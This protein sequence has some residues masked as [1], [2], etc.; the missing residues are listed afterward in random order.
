MA[1]VTL[2]CNSKREAMPSPYAGKP[3][4]S[5][6]KMHVGCMS[7]IFHFLQKHGHGRKRL[8]PDSRSKK[9]KK[10]STTPQKPKSESPQKTSPCEETKPQKSP[11][12][13]QATELRRFS[14]DIPRSPT[15]SQD[16]RNNWRSNSVSSGFRQMG[17]PEKLQ[18]PPG[19]VARLMGLEE[20]P[21]PR[22]LNL[23]EN[24]PEKPQEISPESAEKKR[25]II[26]GALEK[27]DEDLR[28]LRKIIEAVQIAEDF[29][30]S[31]I[32]V[33]DF[34]RPAPRTEDLKNT[35]FEDEEIIKSPLIR[36]LRTCQPSVEEFRR[37]PPSKAGGKAVR[38]SMENR[39]HLPTNPRVRCEFPEKRC[40]DFNSEQPSPV[41]VLD[42]GFFGDD[43][44]PSSAE[45]RL[46][47]DVND[48]DFQ[49]VHTKEFLINKLSFASSPPISCH[50]NNPTAGI[51][52]LTVKKLDSSN[53]K[54]QS[55]ETWENDVWEEGWEKGRV[56]AVLEGKIFG[57][58]IEEI[59]WEL[60]LW[61]APLRPPPNC[62]KRI[63]F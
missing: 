51:L 26:L 27:C 54:L 7:G 3:S 32:K 18:R 8:T 47:P 13:L 23:P 48:K 40:V 55:L 41:S 6:R 24:L 56:G 42:G 44:S 15:L 16:I 43:F 46:K 62:R 21:S 45:E 39:D 5:D 53:L 63:C 33:E 34:K 61:N 28:A 60:G 2:S 22:C 59:V 19:L 57:E 30:I 50:I 36:E 29:K 4:S 10:N 11:E 37:S 14:C 35:G 17:S 9:P 52:R 12:K 38:A 49:G 25:R 58:L 20:L 31:A 1:T